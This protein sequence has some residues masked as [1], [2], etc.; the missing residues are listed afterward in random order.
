MIPI[1]TLAFIL[2]MALLSAFLYVYL[3][4]RIGKEKDTSILMRLSRAWYKPYGSL[5]IY[6]ML[7]QLKLI[8][9]LTKVISFLILTG[10][11]SLF[12]D[13]GANARIPAMIVLGIATLHSFLIYKEHAFKEVY[14]SF[15]RNLPLNRVKLFFSFTIVYFLMVLP[16]SLWLF[17]K[18]PIWIALS[19]IVLGCSICLLFRSLVY[20]TG[21]KIYKYLLYTFG[22]FILLF[23]LIMF[24]QIWLLTTSALILYILIFNFNY[25]KEKIEVKF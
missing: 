5:F 7:D 9:L 4:N 25:Y 18:F 24:D 1:I 6:H 3:V 10:I 2:T 15:S 21:L 11:L 22:S 13:D 16:E 17:S 20:L 12:A 23:Y 19:V 8:F 14:L